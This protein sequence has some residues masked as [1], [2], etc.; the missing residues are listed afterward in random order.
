MKRLATGLISLLLALALCVSASAAGT[1]EYVYSTVQAPQI[2]SI[3]GEWAVLGLARGGYAAGAGYY[4]G[5]RARVESSLKAKGGV[6]SARRYTEYSRVILALT[7]VGVDARSAAGYDLTLPLGDYEKTVAQGLNGAIFALLALDSANYPT[8]RSASANIPATRQ[9]Y[10]G[11]ILARQRADGGW[12]LSGTRAEA[13]V[14]AMALQALAKYRAQKPVA[15]AVDKGVACLSRLQGADGA[16]ASDGEPT[17]ESCAQVILALCELGISVDDA[18]FVKNGRSV[19][20]AL[21]DF[22]METGGFRHL[23]SGGADQMAS[24]QALLA[25]ASLSRLAQGKTS[26]YRMRDA[27]TLR[28]A[29]T[30]FS[31][32]RGHRYRSAVETLAA[33]GAVNG[34]SADRFAPDDGLTRAEFAAIL[35][36]AAG[37]PPET[38]GAFSDV[39][40]GS[41]YAP[42]VGA[43]QA[44]GVV[45]GVSHDRFAPDAPIARQE[46]AVMLSRAAALCGLDTSSSGGAYAGVAGWAGPGV[47]WCVAN[48]VLSANDLRPTDNVTRGEMADMLVSLLKLANML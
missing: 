47:A 42:Y 32:I 25:L 18:R 20:D 6:L 30:S 9:M 40:P 45:K 33:L 15:A 37:L 19:S 17:A 34:K 39:A 10:V 5:Y 36:R 24:E 21:E 23:K 43:A 35:V 41:W 8:P 27:L 29:Q 48:G 31:D 22:C 38:S 44:S 12:A 2:A 46:A 13:D 3:G 11:T 7:A 14:T 26:L 28:P 1:A 4:D 16:F